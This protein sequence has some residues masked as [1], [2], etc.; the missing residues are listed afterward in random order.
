MTLRT[1]FALAAV[2]T[3]TAC[4]ENDPTGITAG[5]RM[6][7]EEQVAIGSALEKAARAL[8]STHRAEDTLLADWI[9]IGGALVSRQGQHGRLSVR[10]QPSGGAATTLDMRG[11]AARVNQGVVRIH[12]VLAWEGLDVAQLRAQR[13]LLLVFSGTIEEGNLPG[14]DGTL[15]GRWIDFTSGAAFPDPYL[16]TSGTA[17]VSGGAFGGA[18]PGVADTEQFTCTT[19]REAILADVTVER[20]GQTID[21]DWDAVVLPSFRIVGSV[22]NP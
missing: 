1:L 2:F 18:C 10:V 21:I 16:A 4:A 17:S 14:I 15:Q 7:V 19:G 3:G 22:F 8:D 9:R 6:T 13:V 11:V 20:S 12:A 5:E